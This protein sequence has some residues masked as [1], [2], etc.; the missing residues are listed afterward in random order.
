MSRPV[1]SLIVIGS[2]TGGPSTLMEIFEDLPVLD[3]AILV[4]QHI[5]PMHDEMLA[6]GISRVCAMP[7]RL[8]HNGD[9]ICRGEILLA[10]AGKHLQ[11]N[12]N[13]KIQL[14]DGD[15][16]NFVRPAIDVTLLSLRQQEN[17]RLYGVILTGMGRDGAAGISHLKKIGGITIAQDEHS[18]I[19]YGM[20]KAAVATG[21]IDFILPQAKIA[22]TLTQMDKKRVSTLMPF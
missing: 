19:I 3:A 14:Y 8:A 22:P 17:M 16:V 11:L 4:I 2:S 18:C 12:N 13:R 1:D 5:Q 9:T 6:Q 20:P 21:H 10:P 7:A 15:K